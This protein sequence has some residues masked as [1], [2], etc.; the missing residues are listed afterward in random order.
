[1]IKPFIARYIFEPLL[2]RFYRKEKTLKYFEEYKKRQWDSLEKNVEV[3]KER[4]Y[5]LLKSSI[6]NINFYKNLAKKENLRIS[7][8]NVFE[9]LKKFPVMTKSLLNSEFSNLHKLSDESRWYYNYSGGSTGEPTKVIQDKQYNAH[10][11]A[12]TRMNYEWAGFNYGDPMIMLWG[13]RGDVLKEKEK[14]SHVFANWI[15]SI[16]VL[17]SFSMDKNQMDRYVK[18]INDKK[19]KMIHAYAQSIN[20]LAIYISENNLKVHSPMSVMTSAGILYPDFRK[21]IEK[22]FNCSVFNRYGSREMGSAACECEKHEGFHISVYTHY[23]EILNEN[24]EPCKEGEL[25][26]IYVTVLINYSLPLIRYKI[27]DK[28]VY[29][30]KKCSCGRGLPLIESVVGRDTD[31]FKTRDGKIID[32]YFF[33]HFISVVYNNGGIDKFQVLQKDYDTI[34]INVVIKD[35]ELFELQKQ[36]VEK[37][38][39]KVLGETC[40]IIWEKVEDIKPIESGKYRYTIREFE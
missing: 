19:P 33:V 36:D 35:P 4:L 9:D 28:A 27:G 22:A 20:Q 6:E 1:M 10:S 24:L 25:G 11:T 13:S 26:D 23:L 16:Q 29:T 34:Q 5:L 8:E 12:I 2:M 40:R 38:Y 30:E 18:I 17:N 15:R 14:N 39:R 21:N 37:S 7:R 3:Q 32:G 31:V